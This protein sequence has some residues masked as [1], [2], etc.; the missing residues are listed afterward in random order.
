MWGEGG[1]VAG[2]S[3]VWAC[4]AL[5][6][7]LGACGLCLESRAGCGCVPHLPGFILLVGSVA[8]YL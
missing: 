5:S 4:L 3:M 7:L 6:L 8:L 1:V 2:G